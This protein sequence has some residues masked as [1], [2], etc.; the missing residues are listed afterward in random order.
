MYSALVQ[1]PMSHAFPDSE[2]VVSVRGLLRAG[3]VTLPTIELTPGF[4]GGMASKRVDAVAQCATLGPRGLLA[5]SPFARLRAVA[6][7]DEDTLP[8]SSHGRDACTIDDPDQDAPP[9]VSGVGPGKG[10]RDDS[11][12]FVFRRKVG[13]GGFG[14][15][16]EAWDSRLDRRVAV[17]LLRPRWGTD[18]RFVDLL[19]REAR[20]ASHLLHPAIVA[21]HDLGRLTDGPPFIV[22]EYVDGKPWHQVFHATAGYVP[23][24]RTAF[25]AMLQLVEG[26]AFGHTR[27]V[28]HRDIKPA[29]VLVSSERLAGRDTFRV[30]IV[31]WGL[32]C[33]VEAANPIGSTFVRTQ[34]GTPAYL[35]PE[36]TTGTAASL[37]ADV[38]AVGVMIHELL[39]GRRPEV[40]GSCDPP[41][42]LLVGDEAL[43][44]IC[45]RCLEA[46]PKLRI[47]RADVLLGLLRDWWRGWQRSEEV[48]DV[49]ARADA[50]ERRAHEVRERVGRL[51]RQA[52][53]LRH[54]IHPSASEGAKLP[55]WSL[56]DNLRRSV[57]EQ[58]RVESDRMAALLGALAIA[59][60]APLVRQ[61][62]A[63]LHQELHQVSEEAGDSAAAARHLAALGAFDDGRHRD[64]LLGA[65][66][67]AVHSNVPFARVEVR[68]LVCVRRRFVVGRVAWE[69]PA[70][71]T[72]VPLP[73]G[74]YQVCVEAPGHHRAQVCLR[75]RR[76][77]RW[78]N[79]RP[80]TNEDLPIEL[81][82]DGALGDDEVYVPAGPH[83]VGAPD[84]VLGAVPPAEVWTDGFI[85]RRRCVSVAEYIDYLDALVMSGRGDEALDR[86]PQQRGAADDVPLY[87]FGQRDNGTFYARPDADGDPVYD[88][89]PVT[90]IRPRDVMA[91]AAWLS[92][93][94]GKPWRL[95]FELEWEKAARSA[96]GRRYP[97]GDHIDASWVRCLEHHRP[98]SRLAIARLSEHP[99][100]RSA[101]GVEQ[102]AGNVFE[103]TASVHRTSG[104]PLGPDGTWS[105]DPAEP[106]AKRVL[107][108][109]AWGRD[110]LRCSASHRTV[111]GEHRTPLAGFRLVRSLD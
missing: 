83:L 102:M 68:H 2:P 84:G 107:R 61:R 44:H 99:A 12:R 75:L 33:L 4:V 81:L 76:N 51:R 39:W 108:G 95:P 32:A 100:D 103:M 23:D 86:A 88:D 50:L 91:Y 34:V 111:L 17:K 109:G 46:D 24:P 7:H 94:D 26:L 25:S 106:S 30:R 31:D 11:G 37:A 65:G 8:E 28:A 16:W 57:A 60:R 55:L 73:H 10:L 41:S 63:D 9:C 74:R 64:Y 80:G 79:V 77:H 53:V 48:A 58:H 22:M 70:G 52:A 92:E 85:M 45:A 19:R 54:Q 43:A 82:P 38:Y 98:D 5:S 87:L 14:E 72:S 62:L 40:P 18:D 56:E 6:N 69:G 49:V 101:T 67:V 20:V 93:R 35:A 105:E 104:P 21:V 42:R 29:N 96:D 1:G 66:V 71:E 110:I 27:E 89:H 97:F 13:F 47:G 15:V 78:R 59:P 90:L 36:I 3:P